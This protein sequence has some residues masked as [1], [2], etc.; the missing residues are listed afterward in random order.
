[1][2]NG[3]IVYHKDDKN[4][5]E[6][7][8]NK[9]L[10]ELNDTDFSLL[11]KE[12]SEVLPYIAQNDIQFVIYRA[13]DYSLLEKFEQMGIRCFNNS[14]TNKIANNKYETFLLA[15]KEGIPSLE[16]SLTKQDNLIYPYVIK[17]VDGHGGQEVYLV[18]NENDELNLW[19]D[20]NKQYVYQRYLPNSF[21]VRLY[22]LNNQLIG[23]VKREN[24]HDFRSNYSLGGQVSLYQPQ[25][26][27]VDAAIKL[28]K[29]LESDYI[30]VD[31]IVDNSGYYLNEIEDP[32]G[33]RMLYQTAQ[34]D[35]IHLFILDIKNK[36]NMLK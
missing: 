3:L 27:M 19:L 2:I 32:V 4:K 18:M 15:E 20:P 10:K 14:L 24:N 26:E 33:A 12:E 28:S 29:I 13:R 17:S 5:N 23:A 7:F 25:K 34:I 31:F 21:D 1:M 36:L 11:Y 22:I 16:A 6:W 8:I 9:C 35:V 30:G